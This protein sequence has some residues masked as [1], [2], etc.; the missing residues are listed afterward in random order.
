MCGELRMREEEA[1]VRPS[2]APEVNEI[3]LSLRTDPN[4]VVRATTEP[5]EDYFLCLSIAYAGEV[6]CKYLLPEGD[7]LI[8]SVPAPVNGLF[9]CM[10]RVILP[11]PGKM[12]DSAKQQAVQSLLN[13]LIKGIMVASNHE[14][15]FILCR[16]NVCVWW[17]GFLAPEYQTKLEN[18]SYQQ[19][20]KPRDFQAAL[21][22]HRQ[23]LANLPDHRIILYVGHELEGNKCMD[24]ELVVIQQKRPTSAG[25]YSFG[26]RIRWVWKQVHN[27]Y[28]IPPSPTAASHDGFGKR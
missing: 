21:E 23:G 25:D 19:L 6:I 14:G 5:T 10:K 13:D 22:K 18:N 12:A 8:T 20:F 1:T 17:S 27:F 4:P 24:R 26:S 11:D 15:I 2:N 16:G 28:V 3:S 7:F 9:N